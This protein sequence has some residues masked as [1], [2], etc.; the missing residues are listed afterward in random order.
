MRKKALYPQCHQKVVLLSF[1]HRHHSVEEKAFF[2][3]NP[4]FNCAESNQVQVLVISA[5][6]DVDFGKLFYYF[7]FEKPK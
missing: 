1:L 5:Y 3:K 4:R 2:W 6:F 7:C